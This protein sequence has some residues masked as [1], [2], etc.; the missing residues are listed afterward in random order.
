MPTDPGGVTFVSCWSCNPRNE[1]Q[2]ESAGFLWR[3]EHWRKSRGD[4]LLK[5]VTTKCGRTGRDIC[6]IRDGCRKQSDH[7]GYGYAHDGS[8]PPY[9]GRTSLAKSSNR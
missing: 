2:A 8:I 9:P 7:K 5:G 3:R 4:V 6:R 1:Q